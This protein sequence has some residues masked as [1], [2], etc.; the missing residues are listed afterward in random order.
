M[1]R[2]PLFH[3]GFAALAVVAAGGGYW[4]AN[5]LLGAASTRTTELQASIAQKRLQIGAN[6]DALRTLL[7]A[8]EERSAIRGYFVSSDTTVPFLEELEAT[9]R[10]LGS[11]VSVVSVAEVTTPRPLLSVALRVEGSFAS[12]MRTVGAIEYGPRDIQVTALTMDTD[13]GAEEGGDMWRATLTLS[14]GAT[15]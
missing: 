11:V 2:N 13:V 10:S 5:H 9:G 1:T 12:V 14:V 3:V 15:L 8:E 6:E 4:Y 7:S